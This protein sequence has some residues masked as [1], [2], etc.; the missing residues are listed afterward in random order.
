M[1]GLLIK[2]L[3]L[4]MTQKL[5]I[6]I[7]GGV[8]CYLLVTGKAE[9]G[10][11]YM[12]FI[13]AILVI[14]TINYDD[15]HNGMSFLLTFP[16]SRKIY[17]IEKYLLGMILIAAAMAAGSVVLII[18]SSAK[19]VDYAP[20]EWFGAGVGSLLSAS[21]FLSGSLPLQLKYGAEKGRMVMATVIICAGVA[22]YTIQQVVKAASIDVSAVVEPFLQADAIKVAAAVCILA[23]GLLALSYVISVAIMKKKQF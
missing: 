13:L 9:F 2:D 4:I 20:Q 16:I 12:A 14:N 18:V 1:K 21:V 5:L 17:V 23:I 8:S 6:F 7:V 10:M 15:H 3:K 22:G 11:S 19:S